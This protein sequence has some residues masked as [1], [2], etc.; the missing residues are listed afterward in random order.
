MRTSL[1]QPERDWLKTSSRAVAIAVR[2]CAS[3]SH[4][5]AD[6]LQVVADQ[7]PD[8]RVRD[9]MIALHRFHGDPGSAASA[10]GHSGYVVDAVPLALFVAARFA[11]SGVA[12]VIE[13]AVSLGG[14]ADT[15]GSIAGQLVGASGLKTPTELLQRVPDFGEV[16][17]AIERFASRIQ[18]GPG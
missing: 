10:F 1:P 2:L 7:L 15:I 4:V 13:E 8:T 17:A 6:L 11:G 5:P 3:Q 18:E 12:A 14:D 16:E 9:R